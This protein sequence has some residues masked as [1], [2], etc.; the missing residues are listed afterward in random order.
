MLPRAPHLAFLLALTSTLTAVPTFA[1]AQAPIARPKPVAGAVVAAKGGEEL[2]LVREPEW[3]PV[4]LQQELLGGDALRTGTIGNLAI[5]F[6]DQ[7]QI[8]VGRNS[9]LVVNQVTNGSSDTQLELPAG[10]VWARAARGGT[11][12]TV[13]TPAAAAAI[14]GTD[15]SLS[16]DSSGRT[17][18]IVLEGVVELKNAQGSVTVRQGEGAVAAIGQAPTKIIIVRPKEREQ[19]LFNLSI[20]NAFTFFPASPLLGAPARA[21]RARLAAIP[22]ERRSAEDWLAAAELAMSFDGVE[23]ARQ[24]LTQAQSRGLLPRQRARAHLV[25]GLLAGAERRWVD[26]AAHLTR[27]EQGLSGRQRIVAAYGRYFA[28][29]LADPKRVVPEPTIGRDDP[30][31]AAAH[32]FTIGF[33]KGLEEAYEEIQQADRRAPSPI[34]SAVQADLAVLLDRR[35]DL[36]QIVDRGVSLDADDPGILIAQARLHGLIDSNLDAALATYRRAALIA[37]GSAEVWNGLALIESE[38]SA[39]IEAEAAFKRAIAADPNNAVPYANY[40]IH[41]LDQDRIHEAGELIE[42][43]LALDPTFSIAYTAKGRY[44]L[45]KGDQAKA[46]EFM[47]AGS[48]ANPA[49]AQGQL[50]LAFAYYMNGDVELSEQ[51]LDNADRLDPH[52]PVTA[53]ART[54]IALDQF[55]ADKAIESARELV[56]RRRQRGGYF[57]ALN[58]NQRAGSYLADAY[59]FLQLNEWARFYGDR[60]FDPFNST[61][62]FDQAANRRLGSTV[63][64]PTIDEVISGRTDSSNLNALYQGL[65]LDPLAVSSRVGRVDLI[66]RPFVD[67]ELGA[68]GFFRRGSAPGLEQSAQVQGFSNALWPTSFLFSAGRSDVNGRRTPGQEEANRGSF[69]VGAAPSAT[70]RLLLFGAAQSFEPGLA[71]L[72]TDTSGYD[73]R[74]V[75]GLRPGAATRGYNNT[76]AY[77]ARESTVYQI[78]GGWSHSFGFRNVLTAAVVA[79]G[80]N[81]ARSRTRQNERAEEFETRIGPIR[82]TDVLDVADYRRAATQGIV[83]S[84]NH[85][86]GFGDFT[87]RYGLEAQAGRTEGFERTIASGATTFT[88]AIAPPV[89]LPPETLSNRLDTRFQGGRGYFDVLWRPSDVV[90]VQAA[91]RQVALDNKGSRRE[92]RTEGRAGI[93]VSPTNG[94]WLRAAYFAETELPLSFSLAPQT[95]V[96][97][98]PA[99]LPLAAGGRTR[100]A[101]ARWDA[102]WTPRVFTSVE[103][104]HQDIRSLVL[105]IDDTLESYTVPKGRI[106][107]VS[108]TLNVWAGEGIGL[109]A[110]VGGANSRD[111][112]PDSLRT[113]LPFV[114]ERFA[115]AGVTWVHP[116][117]LKFTLAQSYIGQRTGDLA[118]TLLKEYWTT[119]AFLSWETPDRRLY[120]SLAAL[121]LLDRRFD[122]APGLPG[123]GR[124]MA[125]T[126]KV[127]F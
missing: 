32:A 68:T 114:A 37:P 91:V 111:Q 89:V 14:R 77:D 70:D 38:R 9:T 118:G 7:T 1:Q 60:V 44:F 100:T 42:K 39:P 11:G 17:S 65:F 29:S 47:L 81:G 117:R 83:A 94:H 82:V 48:V 6:A 46:L 96:G 59:R 85:A 20:R 107:R 113:A 78:G 101:A 126:V 10:N 102:E 110:T 99:P 50:A 75:R 120:L 69:F 16:V 55:Q 92:D 98:L 45:Q 115:K 112:S 124:T 123:P 108:G 74:N 88:P 76:F 28:T 4:A 127:R 41:L 119:D 30:V 63:G 86:M 64:R 73:L 34:V 104:Q 125:A 121:N 61:S 36:R 90:E 116:S 87:I 109:F 58:A 15:W 25:E 67:A 2:R 22:V 21:E 79:S 49:Y 72:S 57:A 35:D 12:V 93:A 52:D 43:A 51:A 13:K 8:R 27:A 103:Y 3:R 105:P 71:T 97:L 54:A 66:R 40:A 18:L 26:A 31:G 24:N 62:F 56:R 122:V 33:A 95:T 53:E 106:E 23:A 80:S 84:L 19:M 5:L